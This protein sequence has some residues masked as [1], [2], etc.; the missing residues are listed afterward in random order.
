MMVKTN[1]LECNVNRQIKKDT[2]RWRFKHYS[3]YQ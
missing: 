3:W 1:K 2:D